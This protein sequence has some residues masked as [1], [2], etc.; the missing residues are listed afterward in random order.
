MHLTQAQSPPSEFSFLLQPPQRRETIK[1]NQTQKP[2]QK[3]NGTNTDLH[4]VMRM[5]EKTNKSQ[6]SGMKKITSSLDFP[7]EKAETNRGDVMFPVNRG[8]GPLMSSHLWPLKRSSESHTADKSATL[9]WS[10]LIG[11]RENVCL[12]IPVLLF[13]SSQL[14]RKPVPVCH[15]NMTEVTHPDGNCL[16]VLCVV[17]YK[18]CLTSVFLLLDLQDSELSQM[19]KISKEE[20]SVSHIRCAGRGL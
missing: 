7:E 18:L 4:T 8:G 19:E 15:T 13:L 12:I 2:L 10:L 16:T 11:T 9:S 20:H 5:S 6:M 14:F 1:A 17:S 3:G